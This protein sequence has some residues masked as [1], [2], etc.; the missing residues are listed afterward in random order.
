MNMEAMYDD[1]SDILDGNACTIGNVDV[2]SSGVNG[3][4]AVH[5]ELLLESDDHVSLEDDP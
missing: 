3:L 4:E 2:D 5:Q 1:I